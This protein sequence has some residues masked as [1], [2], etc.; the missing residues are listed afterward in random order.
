M[1][2]FIPFIFF[3]SHLCDFFLILL[4]FN[5]PCSLNNK[6]RTRYGDALQTLN[7]VFVSSIQS[8]GIVSFIYLF[9]TF[10]SAVKFK[11]FGWLAEKK[12]VVL[13]DRWHFSDF[14]KEMDSPY[15][16]PYLSPYHWPVVV[17]VVVSCNTY[18]PIALNTVG[19]LMFIQRKRR[20]W[21]VEL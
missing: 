9:A 3:F 16:I 2:L 7:V 5:T 6:Q 20:K 18:S 8:H 21:D 12:N 19:R 11:S 13:A 10:F 1:T 17:I 14:T 4:C 15:P